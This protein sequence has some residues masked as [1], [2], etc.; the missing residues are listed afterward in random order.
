MEVLELLPAKAMIFF[1]GFKGIQNKK[2][3]LDRMAL[4]ITL[5]FFKYA[6]DDFL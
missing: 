5:N 4:I 3:T 1:I 2:A 6:T